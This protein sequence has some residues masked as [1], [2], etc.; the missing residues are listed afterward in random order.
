[1]VTS[2]TASIGSLVICH[3]PMPTMMRTRRRR[4]IAP[5][6]E[7]EDTRD[8]S[9]DLFEFG[10]QQE[11][12]GGGDRRPGLEAGDDGNEPAAAA[13]GLDRLRLEAVTGPNEDDGAIPIVCTASCGTITPS[14]TA[15]AAREM[16]AWTSCP[17][18]S[19]PASPFGSM[20]TVAARL[21][22][23]DHA[24]R[25]PDAALDGAAVADGEFDA[26]A[27]AHAP[28]VCRRNAGR[29][30]QTA[31]IGNAEQFRFPAATNR[32]DWREPT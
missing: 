10:F 20:T 19:K 2:G 3:A 16:R 23:I 18:A 31:R 30:L 15:P 21:W 25:G 32:R 4:T 26:I 6:R 29:D 5:C 27:C 8:H 9:A 7:A 12:V 24:G 13:A 14:L 11:S 1:L 22:R 28:G 17:G